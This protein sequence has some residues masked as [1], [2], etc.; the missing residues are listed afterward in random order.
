MGCEPDGGIAPLTTLPGE[1]AN[2]V[3]GRVQHRVYILIDDCNLTVS[4]QFAT[5]YELFQALACLQNVLTIKFVG[6]R[7]TPRSIVGIVYGRPSHET[8]I[9]WV[10]VEDV[11]QIGD[12]AQRVVDNFPACVVGFNR[13]GYSTPSYNPRRFEHPG[14]NTPAIMATLLGPNP[15]L[16]VESN[17]PILTIRKAAMFWVHNGVPVANPIAVAMRAAAT[18]ADV[19]DMHLDLWKLYRVAASLF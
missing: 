5:S 15:W 16:G 19:P 10:H 4:E 18:S 8:P 17:P 11:V 3:S 1:P 9:G 13:P 12:V 7:G 6:R 14:A 2:P